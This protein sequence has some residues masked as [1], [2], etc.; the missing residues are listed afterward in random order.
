MEESGIVKRYSKSVDDNRI[1]RSFDYRA[2]LYLYA[3]QSYSDSRT[4][5]N[6]RTHTLVQ[7]RSRTVKGVLPVESYYV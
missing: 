7:G 6:I 4:V 3:V 5:Q 2:R 1:R